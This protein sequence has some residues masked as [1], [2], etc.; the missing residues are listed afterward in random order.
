[1]TTTKRTTARLNTTCGQVEVTEWKGD[2]KDSE[3]IRIETPGSMTTVYLSQIE[4]GEHDHMHGVNIH[5]HNELTSMSDWGKSVRL[6]FGSDRTHTDLY[7]LMSVDE[8]IAAL[9]R[10]RKG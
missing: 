3:H 5:L 9:Q 6:R 2:G 4:M 1:M 10:L 7:I 8:L